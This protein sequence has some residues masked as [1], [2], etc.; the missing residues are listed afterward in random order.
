ME[1]GFRLSLQP[2]F[3]I[4]KLTEPVLFFVNKPD[5]SRL[6]VTICLF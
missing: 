4:I 2:L 5:L 3:N 1:A 6:N